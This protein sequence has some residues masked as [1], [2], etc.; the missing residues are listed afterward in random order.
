LDCLNQPTLSFSADP[1]YPNYFKIKNE[2]VPTGSSD[3]PI[4]GT[5]VKRSDANEECD[6]ELQLQEEECFFKPV[7]EQVN[8]GKGYLNLNR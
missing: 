7:P 5:W 8:P 3:V 1:L 6:P 2:I 4:D